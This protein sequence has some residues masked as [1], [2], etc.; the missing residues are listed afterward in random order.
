LAWEAGIL[1]KEQSQ[2]NPAFPPRYF[3]GRPGP[4]PCSCAHTVCETAPGFFARVRYYRGSLSRGERLYLK[5]VPGG[6]PTDAR[7]V[8]EPESTFFSTS[9][10]AKAPRPLEGGFE[11]GGGH[12]LQQ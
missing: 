4:V 12:I 2:Q 9:D 5:P 1:R 3:G 8:V 11:S 10:P 7:L 6:E